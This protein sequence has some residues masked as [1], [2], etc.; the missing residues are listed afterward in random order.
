M[1]VTRPVPPCFKDKSM[2]QSFYDRISLFPNRND[3]FF[4][5]TRFVFWNGQCM[6]SGNVLVG[7]LIS[8]VK[9]NYAVNFLNLELGPVLINV[10][11]WKCHLLESYNYKSGRY[12]GIFP[13]RKGRPYSEDYM[14]CLFHLVCRLSISQR[15]AYESLNVI[16]KLTK[17][18]CS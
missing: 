9:R 8:Y 1:D 15:A 17:N 2:T 6:S 14:Y 10:Y 12:D 16:S 18:C 7:Y 4:K 5:D 11:N 13:I 3:L